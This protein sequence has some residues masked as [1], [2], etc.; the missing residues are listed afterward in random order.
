MGPYATSTSH[1]VVPIDIGHEEKV[2]KSKMKETNAFALTFGNMIVAM[3]LKPE[4]P[5]WAGGV[6]ST[7]SGYL[8][9]TSFS[10]D[11]NWAQEVQ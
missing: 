8:T 4:V 7:E 3:A 11:R 9:A 1:L 10:C 5:S 6:I 2:S